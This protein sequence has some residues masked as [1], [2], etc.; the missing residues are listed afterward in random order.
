MAGLTGNVRA[1]NEPGSCHRLETPRNRQAPAG[2]PGSGL[3]SA[4]CS[5]RPMS[6]PSSGDVT[7]LPASRGGCC[8]CSVRRGARR[9]GI[10]RR[11]S[12][13][14]AVPGEA[15]PGCARSCAGGTRSEPGDG[16][17]QRERQS[18]LEAAVRALPS[19]AWILHSHAPAGLEVT[20]LG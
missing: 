1:M 13:L 6:V 3:T 20:L 15:G 10:V 9:G 8:A 5:P 2:S 17:A 16:R 19:G 4:A 7:R 14:T 12:P 18:A 11:R